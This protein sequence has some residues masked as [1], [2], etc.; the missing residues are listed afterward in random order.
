MW[1]SPVQGQ[2]G[3]ECKS[4]WRGDLPSGCQHGARAARAPLGATLL[5]SV[6]RG[7]GPAGRTRADVAESAA[8][9]ST[10]GPKPGPSP[11]PEPLFSPSA[12]SPSSR[13]TA[14]FSVWPARPGRA[15]EHRPL[16]RCPPVCRA[17][18]T[19]TNS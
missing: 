13:M 17:V 18:R 1:D 16:Q 19:L 3:L 14:L 5:A 6:H 9:P 4:E 15:R 2:P 11:G 10:G 12:V 7:G 8:W